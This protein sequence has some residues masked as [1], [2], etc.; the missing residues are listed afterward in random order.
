MVPDAMETSGSDNPPLDR[1]ARYRAATELFDA[2]RD[3]P[4]EEAR[5]RV[6]AHPRADVRDDVTAMLAADRA[7]A[8][9]VRTIVDVSG[10]IAEVQAPP[11]IPS[12]V[13]EYKVTGLLG[14]GG[15][16]VVLKGV[17]PRTGGDVAI[18]V[19]GIGAWSSR[20]LGRFRQEIKL[21]GHLSHPGIARILDAGT[22]R[23]GVSPHPYFVM[24]FVDGP[25][26]AAWRRAAPRGTREVVSLFA[27]LADAVA[28]SHARGITHRDLKP[29]NVL[30]AEDGRPKI[31]DF[32]V[33]TV[34]AGADPDLD[35]LRTLTLTLG[36]G[37][38]ANPLDLSRASESGDGGVIGTL[39]YMSPEQISGKQLVD[40]R[41]DLYSLGVMLFEALTGRLPYEISGRSI[42]EA[43]TVIRTD[44]PPTLGRLDRTLR[45]DLEVI[46]SRLLEKRPVDRY[47][48]AQELLG[49][50]R[51]YLDGRRTLARPI[52]WRVRVVRF[53]RRY[54]GYV[55]AS[56]VLGC[57]A[58]GSLAYAGYLVAAERMAE[59]RRV[60]TE[61]DAMRLNLSTAAFAVGRGQP[62]E[63]LAGLRQVPENLRNWAW[64]AIDRHHGRGSVVSYVYYAPADLHPRGDRVFVREGFEGESVA[65]YDLRSGTRDSLDLS[66]PGVPFAVS[67]DGTRMVR[68]SVREGQVVVRSTVDGAVLDVVACPLA[69]IDAIRWSGDGALLVMAN[70]AGEIGA[71]DV[72][73]G[74]TQRVE[75]GWI[76][77]AARTVQLGIVDRT[78]LAAPEGGDAIH[79]WRLPTL[80]GTGETRRIALDALTVSRVDAVRLG[81]VLHAAVGTEQGAI[82]LVDVERG[83][84]ARR[85]D[86]ASSPVTTMAI[87]PGRALLVAG[88]S[89]RVDQRRGVVQAWD[90]STGEPAGTL[91]V[92]RA[93]LSAA[94]S[95][96]GGT[97]FVGEVSGELKRFSVER[98]LLVP[99][100]GGGSSRIERMSFAEGG[101]MVVSTAEG[102][103]WWNWDIDRQASRAR[104][105]RWPLPSEAI[106]GRPFAVLAAGGERRQA[107]LAVVDGAAARVRFYAE[108]GAE[109]GSAT[110][111]M[112]REV[113]AAVSLAPT[114]RGFILG[115]DSR[116]AS[117]AVDFADGVP[118]VE[119][120]GSIACAG[121]VRSVSA[122]PDGR[123]L[124][125][126]VDAP[127]EP[128]AA[129]VGLV[130]SGGGSLSQS[131]QHALRRAPAG[132]SE[133]AAISA[134]GTCVFA[135]SGAAELA[136]F[137]ATLGASIFAAR[138]FA[139]WNIDRAA[140][141][142]CMSPDGRAIAVRFADG[143]VRVIEIDAA[144]A[145]KERGP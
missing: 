3:L 39:P 49:D 19:L 5:A 97:L 118:R 32:G 65:V 90:L 21:L 35:P 22:D 4:A 121:T 79:V 133:G 67:P 42:G 119:E 112:P 11:E 43:A 75:L 53:A 33:A 46:V 85:I 15:G 73:T 31:L 80:G 82:A 91:G 7:E 100:L 17:C 9:K 125:A 41:S 78:V 48:S 136:V 36:L 40:A 86:F 57:I 25:T 6:A 120:R 44:I 59:I 76:V 131:W 110:I 64:H 94:F 61:V 138:D 95:A 107:V 145:S 62:Q 108:S 27:D 10:V 132:G 52:P 84:T 29:S 109:I 124:A 137:E 71:I 128:D 114:A 14:Q 89:E 140:E 117:Y 60:A 72:A 104:L 2:V 134:D 129:L 103:F 30:V 20:V 50:L 143:S 106:A 142:L 96:D 111:H 69:E 127:G 8:A 123:A 18:K 12:M 37:A 1:V 122:T 63:S 51:R 34:A 81:G 93:P 102:A 77:P 55:A 139:P 135:V 74:A 130:A 58:L 70:R 38:L 115:F 16:G 88:C 45:G 23:S 144:V 83:A 13:G 105:E 28:Y 56:A 54:P 26:L 66:R 98:E 141:E 113:D 126:I 99:S 47:Q 87:E 68:G 24:E 116:V 92:Q 101:R